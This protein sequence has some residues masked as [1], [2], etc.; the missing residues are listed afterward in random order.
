MMIDVN[1]SCRPITLVC[2]LQRK[3]AQFSPQY[4]HV[5][6]FTRGILVYTV[7]IYDY[8]YYKWEKIEILIEINLLKERHKIILSEKK[9]IIVCC[10]Y[11]QDMNDA[12]SHCFHPITQSLRI[13]TSHPE[14]PC[15]AYRHHSIY[16]YDIYLCGLLKYTYISLWRARTPVPKLYIH[17]FIA[18][19][20]ARMC[21]EWS[22]KCEFLY[23]GMLIATQL[24]L[25]SQRLTKEEGNPW[26]CDI[27]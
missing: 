12:M 3:Y 8:C 21:R 6:C 15:I 19:V 10:V 4:L 24:S 26:G 5:R 20:W 14:S 1:K 11:S 9:L 25:F 18:D 22:E 27:K 7:F 16:W 17:S 23:L 2:I 13:V